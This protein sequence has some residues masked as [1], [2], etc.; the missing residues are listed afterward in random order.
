MINV[1]IDGQAVAVDE[2]QTLLEAAT[3][4][5]ID[6]P[7]LCGLNKNGEKK[8]HVNY[9]SLKSKD[10]AQRAHVKFILVRG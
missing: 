3:H 4:C 6:I 10:R 9:A 2:Q 1:T 7:S 5:Q 8:Y